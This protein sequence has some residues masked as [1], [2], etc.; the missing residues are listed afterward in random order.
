[1]RRAGLRSQ[2]KRCTRYARPGVN[3]AWGIRSF[4]EATERCGQ[5]LP[6]ALGKVCLRAGLARGGSGG[7]GFFY[8]GGDGNY[9]VDAGEMEDFAHARGHAGGDHFHALFI[10]MNHVGDD[11]AEAA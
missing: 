6:T 1:M 3:F 5:L 7:F 8:G 2:V 9:A 11:D 4:G 10:A